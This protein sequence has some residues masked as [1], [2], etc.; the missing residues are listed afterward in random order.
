MVAEIWEGH[1]C[2]FGQLVDED[3]GKRDGTIFTA[4]S[5]GSVIAQISI[6][7]PLTHLKFEDRMDPTRR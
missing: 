1:T 5:R 3:S 4:I 6:W 7:V 2:W